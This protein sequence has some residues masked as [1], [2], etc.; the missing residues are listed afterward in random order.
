MADRWFSGRW[1][2]DGGFWFEAMVLMTVGY[3]QP[4]MHGKLTKIFSKEVSL[5][6]DPIDY[7][8]HE[9]EGQSLGFFDRLTCG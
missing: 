8:Q 1:E 3:F 4:V 7:I 5:D 9:A 6:G 2:I